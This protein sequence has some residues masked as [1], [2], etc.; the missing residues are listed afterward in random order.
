MITCGVTL[1]SNDYISLK[2]GVHPDLKVVAEVG[3][4]YV[5][6]YRRYIPDQEELDIIGIHIW[7]NADRRSIFYEYEIDDLITVLTWWRDH[8]PERGR[9]VRS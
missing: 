8:R 3:G 4:N 9:N 5:T 1:L 2:D 7:D 6:E